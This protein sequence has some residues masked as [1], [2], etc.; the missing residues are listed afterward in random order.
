MDSTRGLVYSLDS[1]SPV[2]SDV[3]MSVKLLLAVAMTLLLPTTTVAKLSKERCPRP[4]VPTTKPAAIHMPQLLTALKAVQTDAGEPAYQVDAGLQA[5]LEQIFS[6]TKVTTKMEQFYAMLFAI[7]NSSPLP[8][9][10]THTLQGE[11]VGEL[12]IKAAV[13]PDASFP[14]TID[15]VRFRKSS[16]T[17]FYEVH[18]TSTQVDLPV[19]GG[20]GFH[21]WHHGMCQHLQKL[22]FQNPFSFYLKQL[23]NG[24]LRA[25]KFNNVLITGEFGTRGLIDIDLNYVELIHVTFLQNTALGKVKARMAKKEFEINQH[26]WFLKLITRIFPDTTKQAIDW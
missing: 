21:T 25:Y 17:P 1:H 3:A 23:E 4:E 12:L 19:N 20:A 13:F 14:Q 7:Q 22:S 9:G 16:L 6:P 2:I 24:D 11:A 15:K 26:S 18:F 8:K 5:E 10:I